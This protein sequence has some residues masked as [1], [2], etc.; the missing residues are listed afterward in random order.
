MK[1][2]R[3]KATSSLPQYL[4]S[5]SFL[6]IEPL[7][8]GRGRAALN[9]DGISQSP[10]ALDTTKCMKPSVGQSSVSRSV[11]SHFLKADLKGK[12]YGQTL[13]YLFLFC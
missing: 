10:W 3:K 6:L 11:M 13:L 12:G 2:D 8:S 1:D 7:T 4:L 5:P 9:Q